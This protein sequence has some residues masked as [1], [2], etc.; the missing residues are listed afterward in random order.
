[1]S[2]PFAHLIPACRS[3]DVAPLLAVIGRPMTR[4]LMG[5][6]LAACMITPGWAQGTPSKV[7]AT[8]STG[9]FAQHA[10]ALAFARALDER[11]GWSDEWA[12]R[13]MRTAE[14]NPQVVRLMTP[15]PSGSPR[16]WAV[17]RG[18]FIEPRRIQAGLQF[19][20]DNEAWLQRAETAFGV[21]AW[22]IV[23]IIGVETLYG[24]HM[25]SF[26]VLDALST[27]AFHF[28]PEHPRAQARSDFFTGELEALLR[29]S[30]EAGVPPTQWRG[31][32]AGAIGL[33]QFMPSNWSLYGVDFDGDGR[34]DL[35]RSAADS[36][37][38]VARYMQAFGWQTGMPTHFPI[39]M[40]ATHDALQT[41]LAPS[42][43]PTFTPE[44]MNTLGARLNAQGLTHPGLLALV[45]LPN[46]D[47]ARGGQP[48]EFVAGT[49]NFY[50]ITRYNQSSFY[51]LA[52]IELGQA[53]EAVWKR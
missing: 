42:I 18:R 16:N 5:A 28:P 51:A 15:A 27:L 40:Q 52:V 41:L 10:P 9:A 43:L 12:Q 31:S 1:M 11:E 39:Q 49:T 21:P 33:P 4:W 50:A 48:T 20:R 53:V 3:I 35:S 25:G 24:Q 13:W 17:Y 29:K 22:L 47:P 44:A 7:R 26:R 8:E 36:I 19:W 37:G 14:F 6:L 34:V 32:F 30:R 2:E 38:S 23:G 46:G 45:E